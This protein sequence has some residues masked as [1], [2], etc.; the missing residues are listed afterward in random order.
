MIVNSNEN[1]AALDRSQGDITSFDNMPI[2]FS[3]SLATNQAALTNF[4]KMTDAEKRQVLEAARNVQS[5]S[6]MQ[7][8]VDSIGDLS[9]K[10]R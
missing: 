6:E 4:A 2:G 3:F 7:S 9:Y 10:M 8:F 5:K 1:N